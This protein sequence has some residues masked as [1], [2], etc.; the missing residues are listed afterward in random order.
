MGARKHIKAEQIK[1]EKKSKYFASLNNCPT[2]PR[3]MR[4]VVDLIRGMDVEK[5]LHLLKMTPNDSAIRLRKL[6]LS[7]IANWQQKNETARV[8]DANL[9]VKTIFVN[10]GR[11]L[12]RL[13]TAPQGRGHRIKKRSNHVTVEIDSRINNTNI[14]S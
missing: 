13:R 9:Y 1:E 4:I 12:K 10:Q 14:E 3:K 5:A 11:S 7:A 8:E 6:V 2:S